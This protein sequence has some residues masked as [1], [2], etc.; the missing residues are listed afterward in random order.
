MTIKQVS[1]RYHISADTLRYYE[2]VGM[3]P[4]VNRTASGIRDYQDEDLKWVELAVCMRGS[5][6]PIEA[7]TEYVRLC[8]LGDASIPDRLHLL[9]NQR[10]SLLEQRRQIDET[11]NCL[12]SKISFYEYAAQIG[13]LPCCC[14]RDC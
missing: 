13:T 5:G 14:K 2:R 8:H 7:M 6:L 10:A 12:D 3:I 1:E 11:L 9:E 4:P